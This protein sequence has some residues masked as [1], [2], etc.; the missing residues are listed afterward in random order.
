MQVKTGIPWFL[1]DLGFFL[2]KGFINIAEGA[3]ERKEHVHSLMKHD[4]QVKKKCQ[5]AFN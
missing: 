3:A 5:V 2:P 4:Y 1:L